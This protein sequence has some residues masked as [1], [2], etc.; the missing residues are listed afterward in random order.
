MKTANILKAICA[1]GLSIA[2][3]WT[4]AGCSGTQAS[5]SSGLVAATV[6]GTEIA[7]D[8]ITAYI[9]SFRE[10]SSLTD[11]AAWGEWMASSSLTPESVREEVIDM[12]TQ[13]ELIKEGAQEL[14]VSVDSS[15]I[16]PYVEKTKANYS[17]DEQWQ[18]A[19]SQ[20]GMTED[21]YRSEL[22]LQLKSQK[23]QETFSA[24]D[25]TEEELVQYAQMYAS[26]YDGAKRSSHILFAADDTATA[27]SVLDQINAGTLD[28][29]AAAQQY[30][31]DTGSAVNGGDVGWDAL[32]SFVTEY[33]DAL[34]GLSKDQVSGLVTSTY[35]THIIK[36]TDVFTAPAEVTST[37]Q[38][39]AEFLDTIK[40]S[41][42]SQKQQEAYSTWLEEKKTSADIVIN[43]MPEG[44]PYY[45]DMSKY[46][47][48]DA[49]ETSESGAATVTNEDGSTT[50][51]NADGT[52]TTNY[53]DGTYTVTSA[54]GL[55]IDTY[56]ASGTKT[57]TETLDASATAS[58]TA[59]A[60]AAT[61]EQPAEAA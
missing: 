40:S 44:L 36:C 58:A 24:D 41:L 46:A 23:L 17:S 3:V 9:E 43:D 29:A 25:P 47:T 11:E 57:A 8:D 38:I 7:E 60:A 18:A 26:A 27:Q 59:D 35:G 61:T 14:N 6:N 15:E 22:E 42:S 20:A 50:T 28:F 48:D 2:C 33:T 32:N 13:R 16:D 12:Y 39:P 56:D 30:S 5:G 4:L 54:D 1:T 10:S 37:D 19:L 51:T 31:T 53:P 55:T 45:V 34:N 49:T 21:E 52:V